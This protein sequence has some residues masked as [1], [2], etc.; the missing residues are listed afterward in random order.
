L[1]EKKERKRNMFL[2]KGGGEK[3]VKELAESRGGK[4]GDARWGIMGY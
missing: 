3:E 1:A 2:G 4:L